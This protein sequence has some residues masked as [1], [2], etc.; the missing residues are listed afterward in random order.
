[1]VEPGETAAEPALG[2]RRPTPPAATV[3][4]GAIALRRDGAPVRFELGEPHYR[5]SEESWAEAGR[6]RAVAS[7]GVDGA[8]LA[9]DVRVDAAPLVLRPAGENVLDNEP[10]DV[11]ADGVQLYLA[12][13]DGRVAAWLAVPDAG[14]DAARVTRASQST[15]ELPLEARW[16]PRPDGGYAL[17][18]RVRLAGRRASRARAASRLDVLVNETTPDA[19]A[20]PRAA[21]AER[22]GGGVRVSSGRPPA[23]RPAHPLRDRRCLARAPSTP[24]ASCST[25]RRTPST[26]PPTVR[27]MKNMGVDRPPARAPARY[28]PNKIEQVA[29]DTREIA[30]LIEH[31]DTLEDA[32]GD[33]VRVAGF[34]ARRRAAKW[35]LV[36]P[37]AAADDLL[38]AAPAGPWPCS[39]AA[40]TRGCRTRRS[41]SRTCA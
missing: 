11:N 12:F 31:F 28:D 29:H 40:R 21:R 35:A 30:A 27:A 23:A 3:P 8:D 16:A 13:P 22:R 2:A 36:E 6:P 24:C 4:R 7:V 38:A 5:R 14:S 41:T 26:S 34:T 17:H 37:R 33:C 10:A 32:I 25:S 39:S 15:T 19:R 20:P 1:V 18:C 9:V